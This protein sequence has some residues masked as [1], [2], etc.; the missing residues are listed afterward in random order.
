LFGVAVPLTGTIP[1]DAFRT[2]LF[3][4]AGDT[5]TD[6]TGPDTAFNQA[7]F[8]RVLPLAA[9]LLTALRN[10]AQ[11]SSDFTTLFGATVPATGTTPTDAFRTVIFGI[12]GDP[13]FN[14]AEFLRVL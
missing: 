3:G 8:L 2:I 4:I 6:G 10:N 9:G 5:D 12:A 1:T 14:Q 7:E 13:L 11:A